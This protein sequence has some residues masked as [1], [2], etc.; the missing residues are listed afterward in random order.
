MIKNV[1]VWLLVIVFGDD[2]VLMAE[3]A[4]NLGMIVFSLRRELRVNLAKIKVIVWG[5]EDGTLC[6]YKFNKS[7]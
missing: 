7:E 6:K 4:E 3:S 2:L 5:G 1:G